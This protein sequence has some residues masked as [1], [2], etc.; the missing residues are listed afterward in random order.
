MNCRQSCTEAFSFL[1]KVPAWYPL[2]SC[3]INP[4]HS[5]WHGKW[6]G[7][8]KPCL[9]GLLTAFHILSEQGLTPLLLLQEGRSARARWLIN[10][11]KHLIRGLCQTLP[12]WI[13]SQIIKNSFFFFFQ[14]SIIPHTNLVDENWTKYTWFFYASFFSRVKWNERKHHLCICNTLTI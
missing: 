9:A 7:V 3:L 2:R 8:H 14:L 11:K 12:R 10:R 4:H 5:G 13:H 6:G 1:W